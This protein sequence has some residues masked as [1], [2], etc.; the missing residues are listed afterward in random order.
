MSVEV[1]D[2]RT[3][4]RTDVIELT[5]GQAWTFHEGGTRDYLHRITRR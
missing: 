5:E 2:V 3:G 1:F 4:E